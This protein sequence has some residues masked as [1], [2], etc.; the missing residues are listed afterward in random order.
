MICYFFDA[1]IEFLNIFGGHMVQ[2]Q[3]RNIMVKKMDCYKR[4]F[5]RTIFWQYVTGVNFKNQVFKANFI[6]AFR[7]YFN[8]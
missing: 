2:L 3:Y 5:G 4:F 6:A 1:K 8:I 7:Y